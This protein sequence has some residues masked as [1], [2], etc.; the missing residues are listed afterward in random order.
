M[1]IYIENIDIDSDIDI[2][3]DLRMIGLAEK[4]LG[5]ERAVAGLFL[6]LKAWKT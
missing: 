4:S 5:P 6:R 3:G 2:E 1:Y